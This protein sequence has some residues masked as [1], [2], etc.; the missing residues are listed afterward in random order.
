ML[1]L[2]KKVRIRMPPKSTYFAFLLTK[3]SII[4]RNSKVLIN[5]APSVSGIHFY[6]YSL[7]DVHVRII[8]WSENSYIIYQ[9]GHWE[10][11]KIVFPFS[12]WDYHIK[13]HNDQNVIKSIKI[14]GVFF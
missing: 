13:V 12:I 10:E 11:W 2:N 7:S 3:L 1:A 8:L 5:W 6:N 9:G 14:V 4:F